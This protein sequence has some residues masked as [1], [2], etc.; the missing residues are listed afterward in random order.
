MGSVRP[1]LL[2]SR[3]ILIRHEAYVLL[4]LVVREHHGDAL[5]KGEVLPREVV[6]LAALVG[7]DRADARPDFFALL[8]F[9]RGFAMVKDIRWCVWHRNVS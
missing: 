5:P 7:P 1:L 2:R 6:P 9:A 3:W 8:V 4:L